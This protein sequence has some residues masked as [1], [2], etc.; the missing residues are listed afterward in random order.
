ML[1]GFPKLPILIAHG[2][3]GAIAGYGL[4]FLGAPFILRMYSLPMRSWYW[5]YPLL[6]GTSALCSAVIG[7]HYTSFSGSQQIVILLLTWS[8]LL[9]TFIDAEHLLLPDMITAP[10][11]ILGLLVNIGKPLFVDFYTA[12]WSSVVAYISL[13][14][15]AE[16][17][18][19]WTGNCGLGK[20]DLKLFGA[21][22]AWFGFT[23]LPY[24][25]L[26]SALSG[27]VWA[28]IGIWSKQYTYQTPIPF[29]PF[30]AG[31][32]GYYLV[33]SRIA[34]DTTYMII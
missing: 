5:R 16:A 6:E 18:Y 29:G 25:L 27:C 31:G 28:A 4:R 8:L 7:I 34:I 13:Y 23:A 20:G 3:V 10:L 17:Y 1:S 11:W 15:F 19:Q 32:A 21:L 33:I 30:L 2:V 24:I 14:L 26:F 9:L 22:G 12:C